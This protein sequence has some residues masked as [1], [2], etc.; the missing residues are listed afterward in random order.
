MAN[1]EFSN[2]ENKMLNTNHGS[3]TVNI[4]NR[5]TEVAARV[6][7]QCAVAVPGAYRGD[8]REYQT[9][10]FAQ[11]DRDSSIVA[12]GLTRMGISRGARLALMVRPG[13]DFV[14]LTFALLKSGAV[15]VLIDPGMGKK[16][17]IRCLEEV[18]PDGFVAIPPVHA[19]RAVLRRKFP[20]ARYN[21][22]VGSRWFWGGATL[23]QLRR[24]D[25][26]VL[27]TADT[28]AGEDA[29]IIFTSGSTG[30]PKGVQYTHGTFAGQVEQICERY[31]IEPG[32]VD[33]A[34]FPLFG[35]FNGAMGVTTVVPDMDASR[36]AS[37]DPAKY[38][39]AIHD[40]NA[41]QSFA[42]PAVWNVVGRYCRDQDVR[43][44]SLRRVLSAGAPV[45]VH[46]LKWMKETIHPAGEVFTPYG[47]TEALP[48]ASVSATEVLAETA[49]RSLAGE[50]TCVGNSFSGIIW[51]VISISDDPIASIGDINELARGEIGEL[52]VRGPVITKEYVTR[53]EANAFA[54]IRDPE[55]EGVWHRMGDVGYLDDQDRFWFCGRKAHRVKAAHGT[56]FTVPCEAIVNAHESIYRTALVG[57]GAGDTKSPVIVAEPWPEKWPTSEGDHLRLRE[58]LAEL[59]G[60]HPLTNRIALR[61]ILLRKSL[62]VDVRH[63]AKI[64][65]E[66]VAVWAAEKLGA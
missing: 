45:P 54:K 36:P 37:V 46:V 1:N 27:P 57:V 38:V 49:S 26:S 13:I 7:D 6:P 5:L 58:E 48:V 34:G 3:V 29:A 18:Q 8:R 25:T 19:L 56:M 39:E 66:K 60:A 21:L 53:T 28:H 63:N 11:L 59:V 42:S 24:D 43:L 16:N 40:W 47:A 32:G 51:K 64:F 61:N 52:I 12:S 23:E 14:S 17:V 30:P 2:R 10:S 22:T 9:M 62:P 65:R 35:L 50:G 33:V 31:K 41:D 20:K 44:P 4:A 15:A 55:I